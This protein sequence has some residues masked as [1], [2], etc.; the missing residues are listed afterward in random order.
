MFILCADVSDANGATAYA[1]GV[2][3]MSRLFISRTNDTFIYPVPL[4]PDGTVICCTDVVDLVLNHLYAYTLSRS[5]V[6]NPV[7]IYGA[8]IL[9]AISSP[10]AYSDLSSFICNS[11]FVSDSNVVFSPAIK[12]S[13]FANTRSDESNICRK[14]VPLFFVSSAIS[15]PFCGI[16]IWVSDTILSDETV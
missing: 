15:V 12:Y 13:I 2:V 1:Y 6:I 11:A 10:G 7:P 5:I 9:I 4:N 14:Y 3:N 8:V 16:S